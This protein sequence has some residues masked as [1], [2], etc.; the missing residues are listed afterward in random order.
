ML[1]TEEFTFH[2]FPKK[3]GIFNKNPKPAVVKKEKPH[4]SP[5]PFVPEFLLSILRGKGSVVGWPLTF[6]SF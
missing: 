3:R 1:L 5:L 6:I 4:L 2:R